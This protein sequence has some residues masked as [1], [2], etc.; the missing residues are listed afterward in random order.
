MVFT[1]SLVS[2]N[3]LMANVS[4]QSDA[5]LTASGQ[6]T[7]LLQDQ[8]TQ[9]QKKKKKKKLTFLTLSAMVPICTC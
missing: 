8:N 4:Q 1:L 6:N 5:S 2:E 7:E 9:I 3:D